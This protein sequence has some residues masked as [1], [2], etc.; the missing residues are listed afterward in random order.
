MSADQAQ[1]RMWR[2][3]E[4]LTV[5]IAGIYLA[6]VLDP[7]WPWWVWVVL[8][9][10]PDL[11]FAGYLFGPATGAITYNLC[12]IYG[13]G[14]GIAALGAMGWGSDIATPWMVAAGFVV[15]AHAGIDR[16][17]G[18]GLKRRAGFHDTDL[19]PIGRKTQG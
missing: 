4:G 10:A 5:A 13:F 9:L 11:S 19:G 17:L 15:M 6:Y 3:L 2:R 7:G 12:H 16:A 14:L 18:F 1:D 8:F